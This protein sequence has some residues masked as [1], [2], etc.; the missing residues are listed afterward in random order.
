MEDRGFSR[1]CAGAVPITGKELS[2]RNRSIQLPSIVAVAVIDSVAMQTVGRLELS[3]RSSMVDSLSHAP[4]R[5]FD[6]GNGNDF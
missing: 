3:R 5:N 4:T 1:A 2:E 6:Y